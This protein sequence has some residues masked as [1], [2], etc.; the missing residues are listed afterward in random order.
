MAAMGQIQ[1]MAAMCANGK[2]APIADL[3]A[4][5]PERGGSTLSGP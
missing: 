5:T 1:S 2:D 3:P 4:L